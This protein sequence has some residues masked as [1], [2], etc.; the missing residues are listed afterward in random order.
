MPNILNYCNY[1]Q[2]IQEVNYYF[3]QQLRG[4]TG[5]SF[6]Y[7]TNHIFSYSNDWLY[8]IKDYMKAYHPIYRDIYRLYK[9]IRF[10][11][12]SSTIMNKS[13]LVSTPFSS[14][15]VHGYIGILEIISTI[16]QSNIEYDNYIVHNNA[17]QGIKDIINLSFP[18]NKIIYIE[19]NTIYYIQ[20]LQ[21]IPI[22][23][24]NY[25]Y[26]SS[27]EI[28]YINT[29]INPLLNEIFFNKQPINNYNNICILKSSKSINLTS[30]GVFNFDDIEKYCNKNNLVNI[31]PTNYSE[32]EYARI[33]NN[34]SNIIFSWGTTFFKGML[35]ISDQCKIIHII[36][37][38]DGFIGQYN[39]SAKPNKYK[40]AEIKY[41]IIT[42]L[43]DLNLIVL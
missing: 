43:D 36:I 21:L 39:N 11:G 5:I 25:H 8:L 13:V 29:N 20:N 34:S 9:M 18:S 3:D 2:S 1:E 16:K 23:N 27:D 42:K 26:S 7:S 30:D 6:A 14:G 41:Y 10:H 19:P 24:H 33:I 22:K 4:N 31:E 28:N 38:G 35:Y 37:Y 17:Q 32:D 40:N 12:S 15:T